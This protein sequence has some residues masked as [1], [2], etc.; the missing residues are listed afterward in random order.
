MPFD[1]IIL[2][3]RLV[4][5]TWIY[6]CS[7]IHH[8]YIHSII[9][10]NQKVTFITYCLQV[11]P[12]EL[13]I[14]LIQVTILLTFYQDQHLESFQSN[15]LILYITLTYYYQKTFEWSMWCS[16]S[17]KT[18]NFLF[19]FVIF[20]RNSKFYLRRHLIFKIYFLLLK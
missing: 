16:Y 18:F 5:V 2:L 9:N 11:L 8:N 1:Y 14:L 15:K 4:Y 19:S 7:N 13:H 10:E 12:D 6:W 17:E 3:F 20:I